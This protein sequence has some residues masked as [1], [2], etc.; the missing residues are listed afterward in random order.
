MIVVSQM[1]PCK[2]QKLPFSVAVRKR[3]KYTW[4]FCLQKTSLIRT[5]SLIKPYTLSW[6]GRTAI[7]R[8]KELI[9]IDI[10]QEGCAR[11]VTYAQVIDVLMAKQKVCKYCTKNFAC[12]VVFIT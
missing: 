6:T 2:G 3:R 10:V 5:S 4:R 7:Y 8:P 9:Y 1:L 11:T 12:S